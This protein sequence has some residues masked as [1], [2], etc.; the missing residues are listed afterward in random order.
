MQDAINLLMLTCASLAALA[1]GVLVAYG[2]CRTAFAAM[3]LHV[4]SIAANAVQPEPQT[5]TSPQTAIL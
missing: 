5:Q 1:F 3:R 4:R 2:I